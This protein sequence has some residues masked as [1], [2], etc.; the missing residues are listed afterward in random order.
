MRQW[1]DKTWR[2][3]WSLWKAAFLI[4]YVQV[5][6]CSRTSMTVVHFL[7]Q[8]DIGLALRKHRAIYST[9]PTLFSPS[10]SLPLHLSFSLV[11]A[12]LLCKQECSVKCVS[13]TGLACPF[14]FSGLSLAQNLSRSPPVPVS[15]SLTV[16][17]HLCLTFTLSLS[18]PLSVF[19]FAQL[20][21]CRFDRYD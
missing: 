6:S 11:F 18:L 20:F 19:S 3:V 10:H 8:T 7:H 5:N 16:A 4:R 15:F 9:A 12:F 13:C 17:F 21:C 14:S 2:L 1:T